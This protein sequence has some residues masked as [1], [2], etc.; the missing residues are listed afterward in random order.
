MNVKYTCMFYNKRFLFFIS[1]Y[2][3]N[4]EK[5]TREDL[6]QDEKDREWSFLNE[7]AFKYKMR[8]DSFN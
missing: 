5:V 3:S 6:F 2:Y 1:Y 4:E 8:N 7:N